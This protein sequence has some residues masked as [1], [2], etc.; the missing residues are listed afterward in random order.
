MTAP[1]P[2]PLRSFADRV[3]T[4]DEHASHRL[5]LL[6][7]AAK[8]LAGEQDTSAE[9][10]LRLAEK[11]E[12]WRYQYLNERP[13]DLA[14]ADQGLVDA[15]DLAANQLS[16]RSPRPPRATRAAIHDASADTGS[17]A[18]AL[19]LLESNTSTEALAS[20]AAALTREHFGQPTAGDVRKRR[21]L[22]YAPLYLSNE[23][24]NHCL[25][26]GFRYPLAI[27]RQH[28]TLNEALA[29]A[30]VLR[31]RGYRRI[32][33]V[34]G[35]F[36]AHLTTDYFSE[37]IAALR[38]RQVS[39]SIEI[40]PQ[41]TESYAQMV[42]AGACGLALY[43]ETYNE[44]LYARYHVRGPKSSYLWRLEAMD[45]AAEAGMPWLSFGFLLGLGNPREEI[46]AL[47]RHA[48]Y[49]HDRFPA[50]TLAFGL[51]RIHN[52]PNTFQVPYP[53]DDDLFVRL[54]CTLRIAFPQAEL[55]LS[56]RELAPM[57]NRLAETCITQIS[58][59]SSTAPG[60][61]AKAADSSS[62]Q[63]HISD[64]RSVAD[65]ANWLETAGFEV[66]WDLPACRCGCNKSL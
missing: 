12:R 18:E 19:D 55:V 63:F 17:I 9:E 46:R 27:P 34:A 25:Y 35:D 14:P 64:H 51:P 16:G 52:A 50:R 22:L 59:G 58:A 57:R 39:P 37:T 33:L 21:M 48:R 32:L 23:C 24:V 20:R 49:I 38:A 11:L 44:T 10:S 30:D 13:G 1:L 6:E 28:L 29:E 60:G 4:T 41:S 66:A 15:L 42:D 56:T 3:R 45:R 47:M 7:R 53:V 36:P 5:P 26:C 54:Y 40:A 2:P 31:S 65:V 43:Q 8:I 62:E 61:Y